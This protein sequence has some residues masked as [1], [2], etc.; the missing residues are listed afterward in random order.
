MGGARKKA[1]GGLGDKGVPGRRAEQLLWARNYPWGHCFSVGET[2]PR[3]RGLP[4]S[5]LP[6]PLAPGVGESFRTMRPKSGDLQAGKYRNFAL[7]AAQPTKRLPLGSRPPRGLGLRSELSLGPA[8]CGQR[9]PRRPHSAGSPHRRSRT[10]RLAVQ[11]LASHFASLSLSF[12]VHKVE[13][14]GFT[15]GV[16]R[17]PCKNLG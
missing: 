16:L 10:R 5:C 7:T 17:F 2:D 14:V 4:A 13:N 15:D 9:P 11:A 6:P 8:N 1:L 12:S 3:G